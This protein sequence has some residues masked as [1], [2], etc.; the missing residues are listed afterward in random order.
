MNDGIEN[1]VN[2]RK[3]ADLINWKCVSR[4][5]KLID[6]EAI[7]HEFIDRWDWDQ[8]SSNPNLPLSVDFIQKFSDKLNFSK[9]SL[10]PKS[11]ELIFKYPDSKR[12]E[13]DKV[14][15]NPGIVYDDQVFDFVFYYFK[16]NFIDGHAIYSKL[17][18]D[19]KKIFLVK[20]FASFNT[21]LSYFLNNYFIELLPWEFICESSSIKLPIDIIEKGKTKLDFNNSG[22]LIIHRNILT[23]DFIKKNWDLFNI[24]NESFYNLPLTIDMLKS[25][26]SQ[27]S[28]YK[29]SFNTYLDWNYE[30]IKS[31]FEKFHPYQIS[32]NQGVYQKL[33]GDTL[34]HDEI[35]QFLQLQLNGYYLQG[36]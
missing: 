10:N 2:F 14:I 22:F 27:I 8:L 12:W 6:N 36:K 35:I 11:I 18:I 24:E 16:K 9:L 5:T 32:I 19:F 17:N 21:N 25:I 3:F 30:F 31:N 33:I 15:A 13:W 28:W 34:S 4:K 7:I 20:L 23:N 29:L 1:L 26:G